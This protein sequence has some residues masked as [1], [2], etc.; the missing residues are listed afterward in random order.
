MFREG[1]RVRIVKILMPDNHPLHAVTGAT[2]R[3]VEILTES[4]SIFYNIHIDNKING[5][6]GYETLVPCVAEELEYV[7]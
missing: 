4:S 5:L 2:G 3:V 1:D 6:V 7:S